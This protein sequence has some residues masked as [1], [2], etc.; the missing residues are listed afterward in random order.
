MTKKSQELAKRK[1][2]KNNIISFF[3]LSPFLFQKK[4]RQEQ[5]NKLLLRILFLENLFVLMVKI[6]Q[7]TKTH[8]HTPSEICIEIA[9]AMLEASMK[10]KNALFS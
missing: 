5:A 9:V 6:I 7:T 3:L 1:I 2:L 10:V 4:T 8:T